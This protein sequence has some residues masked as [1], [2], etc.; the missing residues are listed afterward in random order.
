MTP[1]VRTRDLFYTTDITGSS[2][3][4]WLQ[5]ASRSPCKAGQTP[6]ECILE[7][8]LALYSFITNS[9]VFC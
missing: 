7:H 6:E 5:S 2:T 1:P 4:T 3:Y 9:L 8:T